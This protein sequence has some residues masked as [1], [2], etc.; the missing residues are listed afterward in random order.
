MSRSFL[1]AMF[2]NKQKHGPAAK[3]HFWIDRVLVVRKTDSSRLSSAW[4]FKRVLASKATKLFDLCARRSCS[5]TYI[6]LLLAR[7]HGTFAALR[8]LRG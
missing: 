2:H 7:P 1:F 4:V 6:V 5:S 3:T 8:L